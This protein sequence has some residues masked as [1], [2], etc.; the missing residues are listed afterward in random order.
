MTLR[1]NEAAQLFRELT[2]RATRGQPD[3]LGEELLVRAS[4]GT[5]SGADR[6]RIATHIARCSDCAREYQIARSLRPLK[7]E[8]RAIFGRPRWMAHAA[9]AMLVLALPII[10]WLAV[11]RQRDAVA[12]AKLERQLTAMP[13]P[14]PR[15][16]TAEIERLRGAVAELS[17]PQVSVPIVDL[18]ADVM[19]GTAHEAVVPGASD[20]F[21]LIL[22]LPDEPTGLAEV[23]LKDSKGATIWQD[24]VTLDRSG[25][26]TLALHRRLVPPGTYSLRIRQ[27]V[28][29]FRVASP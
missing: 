16:D 17:R 13:A 24:R 25:T 29:H 15:T 4:S 8:A 1:E 20:I 22:H 26:I 9:A 21:T 27:T 14:A 2:A 7:S 5:L 6:E 23:E 3:C 11:L 18:D 28:F 10:V 19:R 12:I